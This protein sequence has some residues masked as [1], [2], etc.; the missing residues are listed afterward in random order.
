MYVAVVA[1]MVVSGRKEMTASVFSSE[2]TTVNTQTRASYTTVNTQTRAS[3][4]HRDSTTQESTSGYPYVPSTRLMDSRSTQ[5]EQ[6]AEYKYFYEGSSNYTN[7]TQEGTEEPN[8]T[9]G[10]R[11]DPVTE[12]DK[13][14]TEDA[15]DHAKGFSESINFTDKTNVQNTIPGNPYQFRNNN[16]DCGETMKAQTYQDMKTEFPDTITTKDTIFRQDRDQPCAWYGLNDKLA[17]NRTNYA[18]QRGVNQKM[19]LTSISNIDHRETNSQRLLKVLIHEDHELNKTLEEA[20]NYTQH[21]LNSGDLELGQE[22]IN[23]TQKYVARRRYWLRYMQLFSLS[24]TDVPLL[25]DGTALQVRDMELKEMETVLSKLQDI[26]RV[27]KIVK[28]NEDNFRTYSHTNN[29]S[30]TSSFLFETEGYLDDLTAAV[31]DIEKIWEQYSLKGYFIFPWNL[32]F[33]LVSDRK[34][35]LG[36]MN[37]SFQ[38]EYMQTMKKKDLEELFQYYIYPGVFMV[39]FVLGVLGN[40]VLLHIFVKHKEI[41]KAPNIMIFNLALT[42]IMNLFANAPLYYVS[43]YYSEW[44]FLDVYGCRVFVTFRFL[45]HTIIELSIVAL[46]AQRYYAVATAL[47]YPTLRRLSARS[48]TILFIL[49][50]WLTALV[51]SL[52]PSIIFEFKDGV[53]FPFVRSQIVVKALDIFYFTFFCFFLPVTMGVF[54][55][56]TARKLRQSVSNM[57]GELR[58]KTRETARYRSAKVVTSLALSYAISH[59]PRSIWFFLVSFFHLNRREMKYIIV[60]EVT[61]YLIFSNS[62]L[63]P[64]ALYIA[65]GTFR[66]LFKR[67]LF[68]VQQNKQ[69]SA[70]LHRQVTASSSTRLVYF[71]DSHAGDKASS[72]TSLKRQS[73]GDGSDV[74]VNINPSVNND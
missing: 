60:D 18:Q 38:E 4:R 9:S 2:D 39:I 55:V 64:L 16:G 35:Y 66:Q 29:Y 67:H 36:A 23:L 17:L 61:N 52:P 37:Q 34:T 12:R 8:K 5:E 56:L 24:K 72:K 19:L 41:R 48:R 10:F 63:N 62:C 42:D 7:R 27:V 70:P 54:S 40:G 50:V 3:Y 21:F 26:H 43:K 13:L 45:N 68:C 14:T 51:L 71:I 47:D 30:A 11:R 6:M 46:S 65:S 49:I 22:A 69:G 33:H 1:A 25:A 32:S 31:S 15:T 59:I 20:W 58:Y 57:P 74:N 44:I 53:C 28:T 73:V